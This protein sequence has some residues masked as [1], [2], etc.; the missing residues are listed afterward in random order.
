[1]SIKCRETLSQLKQ[2]KKR[3]EMSITSPRYCFIML[4][5]DARLYNLNAK[6]RLPL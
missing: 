4:N 3:C 2:I 6:R 1:M 5:N